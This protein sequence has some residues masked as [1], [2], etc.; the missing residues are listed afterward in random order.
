[1]PYLARFTAFLVPICLSCRYPVLF[2]FPLA[3]PL[4][5]SL[6]GLPSSLFC[7]L[8]LRIGFSFTLTFVFR[9]P[10]HPFCLRFFN[11][12]R[13]FAC[14]LP[15]VLFLACPSFFLRIAPSSYFLFHSSGTLYYFS[16]SLAFFFSST[17]RIP[18]LSL[19][20][21]SPS[22]LVKLVFRLLRR[23]VALVSVLG[24][25][26]WWSYFASFL[27]LFFFSF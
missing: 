10:L 14:S 13:V 11:L 2:I 27:L 22:S 17:W 7:L 12:L 5:Y 26:M 4:F 9:P 1:M 19:V 23:T 6:L 8:P 25:L 18:F 24:L 21:V 3:V 20:D 16:V 15:L